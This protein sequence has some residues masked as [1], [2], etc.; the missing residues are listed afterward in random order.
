MWH[1]SMHIKS[2]HYTRQSH[3]S[4]IVSL[5]EQLYSG[6]SR[7]FWTQSIYNIQFYF[8]CEYE[9]LLLWTEGA[10]E[11]GPHQREWA[12]L[13]LFFGEPQGA[14]LSLLSGG[15]VQGGVGGGWHLHT[16]CHWVL[17]RRTTVATSRP[18]LWCSWELHN[19]T[20]LLEWPVHHTWGT[21]QPQSHLELCNWME[22]GQLL[23]S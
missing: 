4:N 3:D 15:A 6:F 13:H 7:H 2:Q 12:L 5:T 22:V 9:W 1:K 10:H 16:C 21:R 17:R 20:P 11:S 8:V 14:P 18:L 23:W 19:W